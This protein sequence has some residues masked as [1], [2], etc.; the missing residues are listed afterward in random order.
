MQALSVSQQNRP[1]IWGMPGGRPPKSKTR[2]EFGQR[3]HDARQA[4]GLSQSQVA[5][6]LGIT[7]PSY[8]DW[9]RSAVALKPDYLP[10]L[11]EVLGVSFE[12]LLGVTPPQ[13][14]G[15]TGPMGKV[16]RIFE[17]VSKLPRHQQQRIISVV[18]AL[19]AQ[20]DSNKAA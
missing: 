5:E 8:A 20:A 6:A 16:R 19:V 2:S 11:S 7:Q 9:E 10:K 17:T 15:A 13:A 14:R 1:Y 3:L 4:K 12:S 18:E